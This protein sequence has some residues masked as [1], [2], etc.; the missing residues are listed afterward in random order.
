ML[1]KADRT[2]KT[3]ETLLNLAYKDL[4]LLPKKLTKIQRLG[5]KVKSKFSQLAEKV[6][7]KTQEMV[8]RIEVKR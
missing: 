1:I 3:Q 5:V 6:K 8:A 7:S 2:I 4:P